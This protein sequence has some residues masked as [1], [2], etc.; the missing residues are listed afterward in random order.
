[1]RIKDVKA[2]SDFTLT[3]LTEDGR[4]GLFD[5]KPYFQFPVFKELEDFSEFQKTFNGGYFIEWD[6]G[7]DLSADSIEANLKELAL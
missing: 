5:I 4:E 3:I 2:N 6:C 1:M 7:A